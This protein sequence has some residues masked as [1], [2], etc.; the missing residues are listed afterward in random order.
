MTE[1]KPG[2][3]LYYKTAT[4]LEKLDDE[5]FG[6]LVRSMLDYGRTGTEPALEGEL[7]IAW[8]FLKE[9]IDEDDAR[10]AKVRTQRQQAV[11]K[12]WDRAREAKAQETGA[13]EKAT[14]WMAAYVRAK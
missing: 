6:R 10:Y 13:R 2:I 8:P 14:D 3:M 11:N 5:T 9:K 7:A 4:A 1:G 12:R